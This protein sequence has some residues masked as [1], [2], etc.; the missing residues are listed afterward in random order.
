MAWG[1]LK[2]QQSVTNRIIHWIRRLKSHLLYKLYRSI[3]SILER[4]S[5]LEQTLRFAQTAMLDYGVKLLPN[6][7]IDNPTG[8]PNL[9]C[10]GAN[11]AIR[12]HLMVFADAGKIT[13]GKDCYVGDGS[14]IWSADSVTIG[15][16]VQISHNVNIHDTNSHSTDP[17]LRYHHLINILANGRVIT[18]DFGIQSQAIVINDDV[19]IG[20]NAIVLK[21][22]TIGRGSIVAAGSV[23]TADVPEFVIVAGNP[24]KVVKSLLKVNESI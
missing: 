8:N 9:I 3:V 12:G 13:L 2:T 22:V 20:F 24:A 5:A 21:G 1:N 6:A 7:T 19:W 10:I 15:D 14:R 18:E 17:T 23:V 11:S 4:G 16:R